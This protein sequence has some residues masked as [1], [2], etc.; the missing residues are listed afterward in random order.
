MY[1]LCSDAS[2]YLREEKKTF[3]QISPIA[4]I[5]MN[6]LASACVLYREM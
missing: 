4:S 1:I 5:I 2:K 6:T 3:G